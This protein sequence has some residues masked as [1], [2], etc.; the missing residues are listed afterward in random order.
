MG[1]ELRIVIGVLA[2]IYLL[3]VFKSAWYGQKAM[4]MLENRSSKPHA[5]ARVEKVVFIKRNPG[6]R[7]LV[8]VYTFQPHNSHN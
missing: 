2:F 7:P 5:E 8:S 1:F 4:I 6:G 3:L